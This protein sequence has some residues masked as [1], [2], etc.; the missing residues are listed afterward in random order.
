MKSK[1]TIAGLLSTAFVFSLALIG[2]GAKAPSSSISA[3]TSST[4]S[5]E[6]VTITIWYEGNDTR[7]P[8][9]DAIEA[10]M[11]KDYPNYSIETVTFDN[12]T[13]TT[14]GLQAITATGGVD[15][16][17]NEATRLLQMNQQSGGALPLWMMS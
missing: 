3:A 9:F 10:E 4:T 13:L 8:Y 12:T 5:T 7:Q 14:K 15:L 17:F 11:Q 16:I 2:C 6:P 1:K